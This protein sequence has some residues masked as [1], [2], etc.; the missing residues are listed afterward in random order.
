MFYLFEKFFMS[1]VRS[2][3]ISE[4][5]HASWSHLLHSH[6]LSQFFCKIKTDF[7]RNGSNNIRRSCLISCC[8]FYFRIRKLA[9]DILRKVS[10]FNL[11]TIKKHKIRNDI[12]VK[13]KS[14]CRIKIYMYES[15]LVFQI[16]I[17]Y[18]DYLF[19]IRIIPDICREC[20]ECSV[21]D[22]LQAYIT[23]I[24]SDSK[25]IFDL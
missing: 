8:I 14:F 10:Y 4:K 12:S 18:F 19:S 22:S 17:S 5:L 1:I 7:F 20:F 11:S 13:R 25:I 3:L 15:Y 9:C 23:R 24:C 2:F 16:C 21:K 6:H